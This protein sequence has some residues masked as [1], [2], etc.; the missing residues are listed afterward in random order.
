MARHS[1]RNKR[2]GTKKLVIISL[3]IILICSIILIIKSVS[4]EHIDNQKQEEISQVLDT[5][6]IPKE[7][8]TSSITERMLQVR[9][10]KKENSE[11][12]GWLQIDGTNISYP[13]CQANNNDYY[14]THTYKKEK[15]SGGSL[16]LDKDYNFS[17]PSENLLIY[18]HRNKK[19][20]MFEELVKYKEEAFYKDHPTIRFTT[21]KE[22]A[23]YEIIAA[24]RSRVYYQDETNVF[25]YYQFVN[26]ENSTD[27]IEYINNAK[28]ASLYNTNKT[29]TMGEQLLTLS[30]CDYEETDGRFVVV[31][32]KSK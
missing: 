12:V 7:Q 15:T 31:A 21:S 24:F 25:R 1:K 20:L 26:A 19:G 28:E 2:N 11:V 9:E 3:L 4:S 5:I 18:G 6:D 32:V 29:A 27:Y 13:V 8:I 17:I 22:D 14:L 10:L 16:F 23:T 30:T